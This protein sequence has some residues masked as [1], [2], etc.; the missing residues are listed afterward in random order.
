MFCPGMPLATLEKFLLSSVELPNI[1]NIVWPLT[2]IVIEAQDIPCV[3][4]K[5][6][7]LQYRLHV[8]VGKVQVIYLH[9]NSSEC[10]I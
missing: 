2:H 6:N 3:A 1:L 8:V 10:I 9:F 7:L 4:F 5:I